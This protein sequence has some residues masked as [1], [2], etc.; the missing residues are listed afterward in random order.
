SL[1]LTSTLWNL[2]STDHSPP[3]LPPLSPSS[4][5]LLKNMDGPPSSRLVSSVPAPTPPMKTCL[6]PHLLPVKPST[7]V[8]KSNLNLLSLLD[9]NKSVPPSL[10][11]V[12]S[13]PSKRPV[14]WSWPTPVDPVSDNGIDETSRRERRTLSS[15]VTTVTSRDVMMPIPLLMP[16]SLP[17]I[18]LQPWLSPEHSTSTP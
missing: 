1:K 14:V 7:T 8:S 2:I 9:R 17:Q 6:V 12:N 11:T 10:G 3:T 16:S 13:P 4:R 18:S 15:R 5:T